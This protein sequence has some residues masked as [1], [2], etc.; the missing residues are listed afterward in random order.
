[1][2]DNQNAY[3]KFNSKQSS[4]R[5]LANEFLHLFKRLSL[6][7]R[8]LLAYNSGNRVLYRITSQIWQWFGQKGKNYSRSFLQE[9]KR[10]L[11]VLQCIFSDFLSPRTTTVLGIKKH[12]SANMSWGSDDLAQFL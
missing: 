3:L 1:M 7:K 5:D 9:A 12:P 4:T 11:H 10:K 2:F 8:I 6:E